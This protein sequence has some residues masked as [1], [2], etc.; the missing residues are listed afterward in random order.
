MNSSDLEQRLREAL[1]R[2]ASRARLVNP[3]RPADRDTSLVP[4][5]QHT[6]RSPQRVV[7]AAAAIALIAT[8]GAVL[9][10]NARDRDAEVTTS[11]DLA[12]ILARGAHVRIAAIPGFESPA[13]GLQGATLHV[14]AAEEDGEV[15][16]EFRINDV[17]V[18]IHCAD[19]RM[20]TGAQSN[21]RDLILGGEVTRKPEDIATL[22]EVNVAVGDL[23]AL[24]IRDLPEHQRVTL[25]HPSQ[26]PPEHASDPGECGELVESVPTNLDGGFFDVVADGHPIETG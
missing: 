9:L 16:G 6:P 12:G 15:T 13:V 17:V 23:V 8:A 19:A 1:H 24:I 7:A 22:D 18:A 5:L 26:L 20:S 11:P 10:N 3:D 2:D 21:G 14:D 4:A 25:Y